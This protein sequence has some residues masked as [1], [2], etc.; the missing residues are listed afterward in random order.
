[1]K[2]FGLG[3]IVTILMASSAHAATTVTAQDLNSLLVH[4]AAPVASVSIGTLSCKASACQES[5]ST[6]ANSGLNSL[7]AMAAAAN[8]DGP[9]QTYP[10]LGKGMSY[11][12]ATSLKAT[13]CFTVME[14]EDMEAIQKEAALSGIKLDIKAADY[15]I[16]GAITALNIQTKKNSFGGGMLPIVGAVSKSTRTAE[17]ALDVRVI[18]VKSASIKDSKSFTATNASASWGLGAAGYGGSGGLFGTSST[19]NSPEIDHVANRSVIDAANFIAD[20]IAG[21]AITVRPAPPAV[22]PKA[23]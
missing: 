10:G 12:L 7:L 21:A 19:T 6:G 15:L 5:N 16:S 4:C 22:D 14:R 9:Q 3:A 8:G 23:R 17:L 20:T 2:P 13:G 1:M 11:A 18:E